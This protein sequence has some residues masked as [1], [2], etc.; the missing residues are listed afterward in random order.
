M[1]QGLIGYDEGK[2]EFEHEEDIADHEKIYV[3]AMSWK[4]DN[5]SVSAIL[6]LSQ[7]FQ[8]FHINVNFLIDILKYLVQSP[9]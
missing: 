8:H 2:F 4:E 6:N 5:R 7:S 1:H 3:R 9:G